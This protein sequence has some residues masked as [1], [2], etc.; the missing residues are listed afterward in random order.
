MKEVIGQIKSWDEAA[1]RGEIEGEDGEAYSFTTQEWTEEEQPQVHGQVLVICQNGRDASQVEYLSIEH[2]PRLK[3]MSYPEEGDVRILSHTRFIGGPWRVRSDALVWIAVAKG[4]HKQNAHFDIKD[5]SGLLKEVDPLIS[6][7]GS[8]IKYGYGLSIELYLKWILIEAQIEYKPGHNL[9]QLIRL[10]P[11]PVLN[12]LRNIYSEYR[13]LC[14]PSFTM[15]QA[16]VHGV[17][18]VELDWSTFDEFIKNIDKQMFIIGRYANPRDYGIF[19]TLSR[20]RSQEMNSYMDS[21]DFFDLADKLLSYMPN[22]DD[23]E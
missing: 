1:L 23:Y 8:V 20:K 13:A 12:N 16:H 2:M 11:Q 10:L 7:R 21:N 5:I 6:L 3:I 18:M 19:Q 9:S 22:L 15:M 17:D 4:L 14:R